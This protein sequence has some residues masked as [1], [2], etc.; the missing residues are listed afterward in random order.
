[1]AHETYRSKRSPLR[2][3]VGAGLLVVVGLVAPACSRAQSQETEGP[4]LNPEPTVDTV[5]ET[6]DPL[7]LQAYRFVVQA[8]V[9]C[10]EAFE[11]TIGAN[12]DGSWIHVG[13]TGEVW[14]VEPAGTMLQPVES[15][16]TAEAAFCDTAGE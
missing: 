14:N 6:E 4:A 12:P 11:G 7:S 16:A 9:V 15:Q 5:I 1:M 2:K 3:Y 13:P 10:P 8:S